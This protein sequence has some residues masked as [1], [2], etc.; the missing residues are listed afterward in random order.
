MSNELNVHD[1]VDPRSSLNVPECISILNLEAIKYKLI[2]EHDWSLEKADYVEIQYKAFLSII[3]IFPEDMCV[4]TEDIDEMWHTHILDTRKYMADCFNVFGTYLHHFPYLGLRGDL[5]KKNLERL[6]DMTKTHFAQMGID[7][8]S[9]DAEECGGG[10]CGGCGGG[11]GGGSGSCAASCSGGTG[12][13]DAPATGGDTPAP[14]P[15]KDSPS[16][17]PASSCGGTTDT[18]RREEEKPNRWPTWL[19]RLRMWHDSLNP[20][21]FENAGRPDRGAVER[22]SRQMSDERILN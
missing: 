21:T 2:K 22:L 20:L 12:S 5:D 4:P 17:P 7:M 16:T 14:S 8:T 6:F 11:G 3:K 10:G 19:P 1:Y 15:S 9:F 13:G 18:G